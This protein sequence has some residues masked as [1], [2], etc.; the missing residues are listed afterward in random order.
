MRIVSALFL[1]KVYKNVKNYLNFILKLLELCDTI[2]L[3]EF[4]RSYNSLG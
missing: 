1:K 2:A 3:D 4:L